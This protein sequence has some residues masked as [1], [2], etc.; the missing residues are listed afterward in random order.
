M[1]S[2]E[3]IICPYCKKKHNK[4]KAIG[5]S[6]LV[7]YAGSTFSMVCDRCGKDFY[8]EYEVRIK[9]KTHKNY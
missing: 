2:E 6:G 3:G 5:N 7:N 4:H 1:V 9:Y 8:G